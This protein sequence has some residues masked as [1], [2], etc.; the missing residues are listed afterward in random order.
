[1]KI[2][3]KS[4]SII[5]V[6]LAI[7]LCFSS[8]TVAFA[9]VE[10]TGSVSVTLNSDKTEYSCGEE[11]KISTKIANN[12]DETQEVSVKYLSTGF[13]RLNK[14]T[15]TASVEAGE[16]KELTQTAKAWRLI[17][18]K[19]KHQSIVDGLMG[20]LW[21]LLYKVL[22]FFS[23]NHEVLE[24]TVDDCPAV[25]L[26][27]VSVSM[28]NDDSNDTTPVLSI[29]KSKFEYN[30]EKD[31][32]SFLDVIDQINGTLK[33]ADNVEKLTFNIQDPYDNLLDAG[34]ITINKNWET[35][36]ADFILGKNT[37]VVTAEY[38]D[39]KTFSEKMIIECYTDAYMNNLQIDSVTDT[40]GDKL[41]DYLETNYTKTDINKPDT[42]SDG[43]TDYEEVYLFEYNPLN[44]DTDNNGVLDSDEDYDEDGLSNIDEIRKG[45]DATYAD[46]DLDGLNDYDEIAVYSTDPLNK[47]TD[48]DG[49]SDGD[50]IRIGSNPLMKEYSFTE[51]QE[52]GEL[53]E[54]SP[55]SVEVSANL[56]S[57]Q[58]GTL[59]ID[60]VTYGDNK[61]ISPTI[62][63]YLGVAYDFSVD[64][65][66]D[67]AEIT[68]NYDD[69]LGKIGDNFQPRIYYLNET[70]KMFEELPDQKIENGK[71]TANT[72]HFSTYI[73]L[74]KIEFDKVWETEIAP[75]LST[76]EGN[77]DNSLDVV[78][79]ID[80]S[81][82]MTW[83]DASGL[84]KK[85]TKEFV[86][87]LRGDVD[88]AA[89][90]SFIK[91]PSIL[92]Q[93]TNNKEQLN[94]A[95]DSIVD[96]N[97]YGVNAGTNGSNAINSAIEVLLSSIALNK[98]IIFLTDGEDTYTSYSY[99]DL[100]TQAKNNNITIYSI[101]LG[102]A[103]ENLLNGIATETGG[104]FYKASTN[105]DLTEI[106]DKIEF[107]T[108]DLTSDKNE[109]LIP[110]Y[111][112]DLLFSGE[113]V[114]S[115][116]SDEFM[117]INFN[118]GEDQNPENLC[119]DFDGDGLLN[120]EELIVR[121]SGDK[122]YIDLISDPC[123][124]YSDSDDY[125]D[126]E[127]RE[128]GSDPLTPSYNS[129]ALNYLI[130]DENYTYY[131]VFKGETGWANSIARNIWSTVTLNWSHKDE[132][133][134]LLTKFLKEQSDLEYVK[135][136]A[137]EAEK[138]MGSN[139]AMQAID[140]AN[141]GIRDAGN[142]WDVVDSVDQ[143]VHLKINMKKW[144][145]AGNSSKNLSSNWWTQFKSQVSLFNRWNK[146]WKWVSKVGNV[147]NY[148]PV[149]G[150][151]LDE[152][153]DIATAAKTYSTLA[154]T[155]ENFI[156]FE[157]ILSTI[158]NNDNMSEK[159]VAKGVQPILN[160]IRDSNYKFT[161]DICRDISVS[162]SEN[163]ASLAV[164]L[165]SLHNPFLIAIN[166]IV[167]L[168]D[169][170]WLRDITEGAYALYVVEEMVNAS[171]TLFDYDDGPSLCSF[172]ESEKINLRFISKARYEGGKYA[173]QI[174]NKQL[175]WGEKDSV[176]RERISN[177]IDIE[178]NTMSVYYNILEL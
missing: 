94:K 170:F 176:A 52:S 8:S 37:L 82:S 16:T 53:T 23:D 160:S 127:E 22:A 41:V 30:K 168:I 12:T 102:D 122:V 90:V 177:A 146:S 36:D 77:K 3:K 63:G 147:M 40:D 73:L 105:M 58:V 44:K 99:S 148:L 85:V 173:K 158:A 140:F 47:D 111:Y 121:H 86:D 68:F 149:V 117:G 13:I 97:G 118:Y 130:G 55:V 150:V 169:S 112:N 66:I 103:D 42:D 131:N 162:T 2:S 24:V 78:F 96:N 137:T 49:V 159:Y 129:T 79:V 10:T 89:I 64:G 67:S 92:C 143:F 76:D 38:K 54:N 161:S 26:A 125:D 70:T 57:E 51:K 84:R 18:P 59:E 141:E 136:I 33:N 31:S 134:G 116:G 20:Y 87:K 139:L 178:N 71:I 56:N 81:Y 39:G 174:T 155:S 175:F 126:F 46:S 17:T 15:A 171:K 106:Y 95:I 74:N 14:Y 61:L 114:L 88:K 109:D 75:P 27:K 142:I 144:I 93:L 98:Y 165:L 119:A 115:N 5:S 128:N 135:K 69:S 50:E 32:Y 113:M 120:G 156:I 43:L 9:A 91:E 100:T 25:V 145:S 65:A 172:E 123:T 167:G 6:L 133:Q 19:E 7:I 157:D 80:Y 60:E 164:T 101:G 104:K 4:R 48:E 107:E 72:S 21:S 28:E 35:N 151:T 154:A 138:E 83:N 45:L 11:I 62:P 124:E 132:A 1:M 29:D 152:I 110:D 153:G 34:T 166:V 163:L 108:I